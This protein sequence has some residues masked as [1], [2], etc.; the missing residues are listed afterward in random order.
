MNP[1]RVEVYKGFGRFWHWTQAALI[2]FLGVTGFEIHG[3]LRFFGYGQAV[4]YHNAAATA[5][6][7]LIAFAIFWLV[8]VLNRFKQ[9][10]EAKAEEAAPPPKSEVL[11]AEIRDAIRERP[12]RS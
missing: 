6:L 12:F 11:L 1:Q 10:E 9:K 4:Q 8:K 3:S 7:I 2:I 5:F